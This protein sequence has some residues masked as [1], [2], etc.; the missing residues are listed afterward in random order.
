M[1]FCISSFFN[2][3]LFPIFRISKSIILWAF[4]PKQRASKGLISARVDMQPEREE[5]LKDNIA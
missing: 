4:D 5:Y 2:T 1:L 3:V